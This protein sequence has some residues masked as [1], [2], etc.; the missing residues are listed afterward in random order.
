VLRPLET[1]FPYLAGVQIL[2]P[3]DTLHGNLEVRHVGI[4]DHRRLAAQLEGDR[5]EVLGGGSK[6]NARTLLI[7]ARGSKS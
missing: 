4:N 7:S 3:E 1:G 6:L 2:A 5:R